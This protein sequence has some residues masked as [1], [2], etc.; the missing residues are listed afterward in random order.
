MWTRVIVFLLA[1]VAAG[2]SIAITLE[3]AQSEAHTWTVTRQ[4]AIQNR[5]DDCIAEGNPRICH[6][7]WAASVLPN[8]APADSA[9]ATVTLDDPGRYMTTPCGDCYDSNSGTFALAG[10]SIPA[11]APL[12]AK[13]N[14]AGSE[15]QTWGVQLVIRIQFDG[16]VYERGY[17][18]GIFSGFAWRELETGP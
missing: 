16:T 4:D 15:S 13:I 8:T 2:P 10:I 1:F 17:G 14:I 12:N 3:E 18:R 11:T 9:L 7:A 6:T 5:V